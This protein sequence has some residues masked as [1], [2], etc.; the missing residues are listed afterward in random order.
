MLPQGQEGE[1]SG[2]SSGLAFQGQL[3]GKGFSLTPWEVTTP[4]R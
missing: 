2:A 3:E 4:Q 1:A